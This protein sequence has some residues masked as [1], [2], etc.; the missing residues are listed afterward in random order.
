MLFLPKGIL[1]SFENNLK[2]GTNEV[3]EKSKIEIIHE[4]KR[5]SILLSS[6]CWT[7]NGKESKDDKK[8]KREKKEEKKEKTKEHGDVKSTRNV[9]CKDYTI[10]CGF[11][12]FSPFKFSLFF[13]LN[14]QVREKKIKIMTR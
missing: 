6:V 13:L 2:E 8:G 5:V 9:V 3:E 7:L 10:V 11:M 14:A 12:P 4:Q 1:L